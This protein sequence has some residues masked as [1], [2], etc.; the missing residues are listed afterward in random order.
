[1]VRGISGA[2]GAG[3]LT[4]RQLTGSRDRYEVRV[5]EEG[6]RGDS[7]NASLRRS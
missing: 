3:M 1:M 4:S 5:I 2:G 6:E 7:K